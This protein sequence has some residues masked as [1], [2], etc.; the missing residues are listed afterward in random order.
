MSKW[1]Q[2]STRG[3]FFYCFQ[4]AMGP[5]GPKGNQVIDIRIA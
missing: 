5:V 3:V 1:G 2:L 4:G